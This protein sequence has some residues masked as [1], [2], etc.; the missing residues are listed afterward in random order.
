M[1]EF[2]FLYRG[3][4]DARSIAQQLGELKER[5]CVTVATGNG[6]TEAMQ[7][8]CRRMFGDSSLDRRRLLVAFGRDPSPTAWL[9]AGLDT[10]HETVTVRDRSA[11]VRDVSTAVPEAQA[12]GEDRDDLAKTRL[13]A[14]AADVLGVAAGMG[15]KRPGRLRVVVLRPDHLF[16]DQDRQSLSVLSDFVTRLRALMQ[17][18]GMALLVVPSRGDPKIVERLRSEVA[19][20]FEVRGKP[21]FVEHRVS[22]IRAPP[23]RS[24]RS[25]TNSTEQC[26][27]L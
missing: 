5:G 18:F 22:S 16:P 10:D 25:G 11:D 4:G 24:A 3:G 19:I 9:P 14:V 7:A 2:D 21:K 1:S 27:R 15:A 23:I 20:E 26:T 6:P 13:D 17:R 8:L 12:T